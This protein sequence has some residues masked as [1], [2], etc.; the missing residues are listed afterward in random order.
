MVVKLNY[1]VLLHV[2]IDYLLKAQ[3]IPSSIRK[4]SFLIFRADACEIEVRTL[5]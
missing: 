2:I 3:G 4:V 1:E 5:N